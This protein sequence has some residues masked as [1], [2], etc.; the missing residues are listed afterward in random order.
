MWDLRCNKR[1]PTSKTQ[2]SEMSHSHPIVG[3]NVVGTKRTCN[4]I[5][6]S[7]E[8]RLCSWPLDKDFSLIIP[9]ET[10][11]LKKEQVLFPEKMK[12]E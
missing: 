4:L 9:T 1:T 5:S 7:S 6:T 3:L 11:E 8:G 2:R 10:H 12:Q